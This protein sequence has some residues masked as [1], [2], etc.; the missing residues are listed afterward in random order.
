MLRRW[1][2]SEG[3]AVLGLVILVTALTGVAFGSPQPTPVCAACGEQFERAADE[4]GIEVNVTRSTLDVYLDANGTATHVVRNHLD[5]GST[6]EL[7][8]GDEVDDVVRRLFDEDSERVSTDI[9]GRTVVLSRRVADAGHRSFGVFVYDEYRRDYDAWWVVNPDRFT[10]HAPPNHRR[11]T[12][13]TADDANET[14]VTW[15]GAA[16]GLVSEDDEFTHRTFVVFAPAGAVAPGIQSWLA[17]V[18]LAAPV[19]LSDVVVLLVPVALVF[20]LASTGVALVVDRPRVGDPRQLAGAVGVLSVLCFVALLGLVDPSNPAWLPGVLAAATCAT[21]AA[22][23]RPG[24]SIQSFPA[25]VLRTAGAVALAVVV[26]TASVNLV[27]PDAVHPFRF[28][29]VSGGL[30]TCFLL[31]YARRVGVRHS[32]VVAA[33]I[34]LPYVGFALSVAPIPRGLPQVFYVLAIGAASLGHVVVGVPLFY[35]GVSLARSVNASPTG[36]A[37]S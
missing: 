32:W 25:A 14:A 13:P 36:T 4:R 6:A 12:D 37:P 31:G 28:L 2:T 7:R 16:G 33:G 11:V 27:E 20:G 24:V 18:A 19:V 34:V 9:D 30:A 35:L 26:A 22:L 17:S 29:V 15:H 1:R 10:V 21:L 8:E 23:A 5:A 3:I